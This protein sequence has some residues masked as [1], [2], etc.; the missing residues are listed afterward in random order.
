[1][2]QTIRI[3]D[4]DFYTAVKETAEIQTRSIGEQATHW[5]KIGKAIEESNNFSYHH[6]KE[7]LTGARSVD[8]LTAE[9]QAVFMDDFDEA[10]NGNLANDF[11]AHFNSL[12]NVDNFHGMNENG[13]IISSK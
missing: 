3:S 11:A 6:V 4:D 12:E 1:M 9:E 10:I 2:A 5:M 8:D 7:A 13:D